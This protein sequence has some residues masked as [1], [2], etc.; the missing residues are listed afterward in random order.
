MAAMATSST[1]EADPQ[2]VAPGS[3]EPP[4]SVDIVPAPSSSSA[5]VHV[6]ADLISAASAS[7]G[8]RGDGVA[9]ERALASMVSYAKASGLEMDL[10]SVQLVRSFSSARMEY[11]FKGTSPLLARILSESE[12]SDLHLPVE[13][14][15]SIQF[16]IRARKTR[17]SSHSSSS[18]S[19]TERAS[20]APSPHFIRLRHLSP[21]LSVFAVKQALIEAG[22]VCRYLEFNYVSVT[23]GEDSAT[24]LDGS[25]FG[26]GEARNQP[27]CGS[28]LRS[29][30]M[31]GDRKIYTTISHAR[32]AYD[33]AAA[34]KRAQDST[35]TTPENG[36]VSSTPSSSPSIPDSADGAVA[37]P[38]AA[39]ASLEQN[40]ST[41]E[42]APKDLVEESTKTQEGSQPTAPPTPA[43]TPSEESAGDAA[44]T[45]KPAPEQP[46]KSAKQA[47]KAPASSTSQAKNVPTKT[48]TPPPGRRETRSTTS[49]SS[50]S[51]STSSSSTSSSA[52]SP[53]STTS[54][55]TKTPKTIINGPAQRATPLLR[56]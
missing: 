37:R 22:F 4:F 10:L 47:P 27:D 12:N 49:A 25:A 50:A 11:T 32:N 54:S 15:D 44:V 13:S 56:K 31:M 8:A 16:I 17:T 45:T 33:V 28:S 18:R 6:F 19:R 43:S 53:P 5:A 52:A 20:L 40:A 41:I 51:T 46:A 38:D 3:S 7:A 26:F 14:R 30:F 9:N 2:G 24:V 36:E 21:E 39:D 23:V 1:T 55:L 48:P 35:K 29:S 34:K 42:P